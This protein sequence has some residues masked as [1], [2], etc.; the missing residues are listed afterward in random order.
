MDL[1]LATLSDLPQIVALLVDDDIARTR[2]ADAGD[3]SPYEAAWAE[4][5]A[6][7]G[8]WIL[9]ACQGDEIL[10]TLQL[11]LIAGL[12]RRGSRRAQIEGVRVK[13][14][15]RGKSVGRELMTYAISMAKD[16]GCSLVQLTTDKR[17][18]DAK[19]FYE[20]LGFDATHEGMK[21]LW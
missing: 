14:A 11:T 3:L 20:S 16:H 15:A 8:N 19:R 9:V 18:P 5:A 17:R 13:S 7:P 12:A 1:R 21:I 4:I 2:E 10:G 6:T